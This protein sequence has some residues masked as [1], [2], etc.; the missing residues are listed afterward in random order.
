MVSATHVVRGVI[1]VS[2]SIIPILVVINTNL[3]IVKTI[4]CYVFPILNDIITVLVINNNFFGSVS[5]VSGSI[6]PVFIIIYT[7]SGV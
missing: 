4:L 3:R 1:L 5:P 2:T 7:V 6:A